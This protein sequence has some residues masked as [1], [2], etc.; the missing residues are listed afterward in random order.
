MLRHGV[1]IQLWSQMGLVRFSSLFQLLGTHSPGWILHLL[2]QLTLE[3]RERSSPTPQIPLVEVQWGWGWGW[4]WAL[5]TVAL[6]LP[7]LPT[8]KEEKGN[9]E[10]KERREEERKG[11]KWRP[12][13]HSNE[14]SG[15]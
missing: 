6:Q 10:E 5:Y 11:M 7:P 3:M 9:E 13:L 12:S 14:S 1:W 4:G 2:H 8:E 15:G